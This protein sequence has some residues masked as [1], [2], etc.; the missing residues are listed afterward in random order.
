MFHEKSTLQSSFRRKLVPDF[1]AQSGAFSGPIRR[2]FRP[3]PAQDSN[4]KNV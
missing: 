3:N 1:Q 2:I 4:M